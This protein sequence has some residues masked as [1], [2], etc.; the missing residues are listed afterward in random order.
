MGVG[1]AIEKGFQDGGALLRGMGID[2]YSLA[3]IEAMEP[4]KIT[5]REHE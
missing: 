2:L 3:I 4:G 5:L 1:I